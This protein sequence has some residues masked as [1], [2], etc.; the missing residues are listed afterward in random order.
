MAEM[1]EW[2]Y[3]WNVVLCGINMNWLY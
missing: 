1:N 2:T 3:L